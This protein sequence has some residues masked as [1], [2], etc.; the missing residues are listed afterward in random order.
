MAESCAASGFSP[1][2]NANNLTS[3]LLQNNTV[4]MAAG[5]EIR[6]L[7]SATIQGLRSGEIGLLTKPMSSN[8]E[9]SGGI[10]IHSPPQKENHNNLL[11]NKNFHEV[12]IGDL[13]RCTSRSTW[14]IFFF[15]EL[16][17]PL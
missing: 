4:R 6:A 11:T 15:F 7:Q 2:K 9:P 3:Q 16:D 10:G 12:S 17:F 13:N 1:C 14:C 5:R 8:R